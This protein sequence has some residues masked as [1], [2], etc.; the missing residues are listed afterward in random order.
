MEYPVS[1][2]N[3]LVLKIKKTT[4][5]APIPARQTKGSAGFD[6][7]YWDGRKEPLVLPPGVVRVLNT[8]IA[9]AVPEGYLLSFRPRSSMGAKGVIIPNSPC[10]I[11]SD[12][13]GEVK[14]PL[15]NLGRAPV[16]I[17]PGDRIAQ[18]LLEVSYIP[19]LE[20]VEELDE[21]DRGENGF[22]ST[23]R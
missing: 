23:G 6:L 16:T 19:R 2:Q 21:T 17:E 11:D 5:E 20:V 22:G 10:T 14:V 9:V 18:A 15:M 1:D 7:Y 8:G 4:Q 3:E 13:R 12:Y